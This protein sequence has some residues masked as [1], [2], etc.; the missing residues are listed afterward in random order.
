MTDSIASPTDTTALRK[1]LEPLEH[2]RVGPG[3]CACGFNAYRIRGIML[4]YGDL[5][6]RHFGWA[7][8]QG[9]YRP[10]DRETALG[11]L[12]EIDRLRALIETAKLAALGRVLGGDA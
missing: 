9:K 8:E 4:D 2:H 12:D 5:L 10:L 11:L 1:Q 6:S 7:K 3:E